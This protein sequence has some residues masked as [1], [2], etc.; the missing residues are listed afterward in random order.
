MSYFV[1][2]ITESRLFLRKDNSDEMA[3]LL[4]SLGNDTPYYVGGQFEIDKTEQPGVVVARAVR[5]EQTITTAQVD[6]LQRMQD[7]GR[8]GPHFFSEGTLDEFLRDLLAD[9]MGV[10]V[11]LIPSDFY[12]VATMSEADEEVMTAVLTIPDEFMLVKPGQITMQI[13][14]PVALP[15]PLLINRMPT[16]ALTAAEL[17][18][19]RC[20][21]G[22]I[23]EPYDTT[24]MRY[25]YPDGVTV[26]YNEQTGLVTVTGQVAAP[27]EVR[28]KI[29]DDL[30]PAPAQ[31]EGA[32]IWGAYQADPVVQG[33]PAAFVFLDTGCVEQREWSLMF[34]GNGRA[35]F[36]V[37]H[38]TPVLQGD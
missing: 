29:H 37:T 25:S 30:V 13:V 16:R 32:S 7:T 24:G 36:R 8:A 38:N 4:Q 12:A 34:T 21:D 19:E 23:L 33:T 14:G 28:F 31:F 6:V 22:R 27:V 17:S 26:D 18:V 35:R 20:I 2:K 1:D 11:D 9:T 15:E 5:V 3:M 10:P